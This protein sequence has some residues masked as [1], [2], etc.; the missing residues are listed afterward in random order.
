MD[1]GLVAGAVV[2]VDDA[3]LVGDPGVGA[4]LH[5]HEGVTGGAPVAPELACWLDGDLEHRV[6]GA[7]SQAEVTCGRYKKTSVN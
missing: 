4:N 3:G 7:Q 2:A 6:S 5:L 1:I